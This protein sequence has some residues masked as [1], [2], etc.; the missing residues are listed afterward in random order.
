MKSPSPSSHG[1]IGTAIDTKATDA[2]RAVGSAFEH[3]AKAI[4]LISA[5][6]PPDDS[7]IRQMTLL[8]PMGWMSP[9]FGKMIMN[10]GRRALASFHERAA[11]SIL[12]EA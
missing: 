2:L 9:A 7:E 5:I 3:N 4:D 8:G 6:R 11:Q 1:D 12:S 10:S